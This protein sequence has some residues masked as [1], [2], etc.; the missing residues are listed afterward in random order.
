MQ[1][2]GKILV[3]FLWIS[4]VS[5]FFCKIVSAADDEFFIFL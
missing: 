3:F 5:P 1:K 2:H 4:Q